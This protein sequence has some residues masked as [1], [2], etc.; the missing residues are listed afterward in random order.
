MAHDPRP[1]ETRTLTMAE[2]EALP[3]MLGKIA[4]AML[5]HRG[6]YGYTDADTGRKVLLRLAGYRASVSPFVRRA[7]AG[8]LPGKVL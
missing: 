6:E 5:A 2:A 7:L 3:G 4:S 8:E 1:D